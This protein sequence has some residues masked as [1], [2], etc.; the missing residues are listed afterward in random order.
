MDPRVE[1][2]L[3]AGAISIVVALISY[4]V[5]GSKIQ[6]ELKAIKLQQRHSFNEKLL[7]LRL[8]AYPEVFDITQ[9]IGKRSQ[10]SDDVIKSIIEESLK[11]LVAWQSKKSGLLLSKSSLEGYYV[12]KNALRK[13]PANNGSYT[14]EQLGKLWKARNKFRSC[15]RNDVGLL[16][17]DE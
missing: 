4:L 17:E 2:A 10:F 9:N 7:E 5:S 16:H 6:A 1:A 14:N 12:L 15:L 3:I 8:V 13:N 11:N